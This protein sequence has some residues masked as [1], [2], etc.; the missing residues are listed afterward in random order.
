M[1]G[2]AATVGL[3]LEFLDRLDQTGAASLTTSRGRSQPAPCEIAAEIQPA[4]VRLA[5]ANTHRQQHAFACSRI[6]RDSWA[7]AAWLHER[8]QP[9]AVRGTSRVSASSRRVTE[10]IGAVPIVYTLPRSRQE[11]A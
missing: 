6:P 5:L 8:A 7:N 4:F 9:V 3:R 10:V 11:P 1:L 2:T